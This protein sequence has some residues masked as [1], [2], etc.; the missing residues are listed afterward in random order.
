MSIISHALTSLVRIKL[1]MKWGL[2]KAEC[3]GESVHILRKNY[4]TY[5]MP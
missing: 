3:M 5:C 1:N 2:V 4:D